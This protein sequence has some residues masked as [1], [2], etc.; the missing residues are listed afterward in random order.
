[1]WSRLFNDPCS[2]KGINLIVD[3]EVYLAIAMLHKIFISPWNS[4]DRSQKPLRVNYLINWHQVCIYHFITT[5]QDW[6][7]ALD[8]KMKLQMSWGQCAWGKRKIC[9]FLLHVFFKFV[10]LI[11]ANA[12]WSN[13]NFNTL[14]LNVVLF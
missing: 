5:L 10:Q 8:K 9:C 12:L 7:S 13:T 6:L 2:L 3:K 11:V 14:V 4:K 1:M